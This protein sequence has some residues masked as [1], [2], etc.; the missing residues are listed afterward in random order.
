M[1][2]EHHIGPEC[3]GRI[4]RALRDNAASP[5]L[6]SVADI[7]HDGVLDRADIDAIAMSAVSLAAHPAGAGKPA[8]P[9]GGT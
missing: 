1:L 6:Q 9:G 7:N 4:Q 8:G 3:A 5:L 2:G